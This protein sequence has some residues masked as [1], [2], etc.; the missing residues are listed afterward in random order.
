M[1]TKNKWFG[2]QHTNGKCFVKRFFDQLDIDE[3][4]ESPF[5]ARTFG[6]FEAV[7]NV[8]A[9]EILKEKI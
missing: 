9:L 7:D 8:E 2:Y 4:D 1:S 3:A 5:V 6:P